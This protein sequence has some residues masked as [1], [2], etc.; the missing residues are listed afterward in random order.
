MV[1]LAMSLSSC[2]GDSFFSA[3]F[4]GAYDKSSRPLFGEI[5][6]GTGS[7]EYGRLSLGSASREEC[8]GEFRV[9]RRPSSFF[10]ISGRAGVFR[11]K[12]YCLDGRSG[13]FEFTSAWPVQGDADGVVTGKVGADR[14]RAELSAGKQ[15]A[16]STRKNACYGNLCQFGVSWEL[17]PQSDWNAARKRLR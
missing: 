8:R 16:S 17:A 13:E 3:G 14:F 1:G 10:G 7:V 6:F 9:V 12:L 11:G 5:Q 15:V 2:I 4:I